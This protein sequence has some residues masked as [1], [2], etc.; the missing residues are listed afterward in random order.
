LER[1]SIQIFIPKQRAK[2]KV[3]NAIEKRMKE[4]QRQ[5]IGVKILA[6]SH[7]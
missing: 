7:C 2:E 1:D 4:K 5:H 3:F 6:L